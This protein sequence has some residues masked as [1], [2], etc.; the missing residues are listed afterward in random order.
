[1]KL[2]KIILLC[3]SLLIS[4]CTATNTP[5]QASKLGKAASMDDM[6]KVIDQ[7]GP[8]VFQKHIAANWHVPL[9]GLLNLDHPKVIAAGIKDREQDIQLFVYTLTHP[10]F[11]TFIVDSGVSTR[12]T[13]AEGNPDI[14]F[15]V[16]KAM[17][18]SDLEVLLTTKQLS[19]DIGDIAGVLLTHIHMDHI[20]GLTD[21]DSDVPVYIGPSGATH[22]T[23]THAVTQGTTDRLLANTSA[24]N[25]WQFSDEGVIDVF[26]DGSLWAIYS[27]GHTPGSTAYLART[28]NGAE[29][30]LGDAAH[31]RWGWDNGV[32]PGVYSEDGPLS[33]ISLSKLLKISE[34]NPNLNVHPGHQN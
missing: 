2:Q 29:L 31:T 24:L 30:M 20:M 19:E 9:S 5:T 8:I 18:I 14:S 28:T 3:L 21:L 27:P 17:N 32:E 25:E 15:L 4:A 16:N 23:I 1:M 13:R 10:E 22:S 26:S 12:F 7:S 33:V 34:Q 11:G 6:L